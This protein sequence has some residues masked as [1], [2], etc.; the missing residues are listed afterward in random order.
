MSEANENFVGD[1]FAFSVVNKTLRFDP[2]GAPG[3]RHGTFFISDEYGISSTNSIARAVLFD[4][5][6]CPLN[7]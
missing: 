6:P 1:I 5:F 2:G 4:G 7:S 3:S